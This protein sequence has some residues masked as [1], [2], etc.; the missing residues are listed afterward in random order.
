[1]AEL[2]TRAE[3]LA[4]REVAE[5]REALQ[6]VQPEISKI[7][8]ALRDRSQGWTMKLSRAKRG[9]ESMC[10]STVAF[11]WDLA[12]RLPLAGQAIKALITHVYMLTYYML[13]LFG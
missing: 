12:W 6:R 11:G 1:M 13:G 4:E 3:R 10:R 5:A 7:S 8:Q 9:C 2:L